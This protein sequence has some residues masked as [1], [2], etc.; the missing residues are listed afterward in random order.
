MENM[1]KITP[2]PFN[3]FDPFERA[4]E[5]EKIVMNGPITYML[6]FRYSAKSLGLSIENISRTLNE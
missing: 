2:E 4:S 5:I 3:P 6:G 1:E